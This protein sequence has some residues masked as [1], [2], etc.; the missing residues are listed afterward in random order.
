M[1]TAPIAQYAMYPK[2]CLKAHIRKGDRA[3][4]IMEP[5]DTYFDIHV[6]TAQIRATH[7]PTSGFKASIVPT[8]DAT[9]FPPV[10]FKN[11]DLLC[12]KRTNIA[13]ITG[14]SPYF[15]YAERKK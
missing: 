15:A 14:V 2:G 4:A 7:I 11:I 5:K 9:D 3:N 1:Y 12:P 6:I 8:P 10:K 13:A